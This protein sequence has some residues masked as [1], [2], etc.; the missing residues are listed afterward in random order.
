MTATYV[1]PDLTGS[2]AHCVAEFSDESQ[3]RFADWMETFFAEGVARYGSVDAF[4]DALRWHNDL[5]HF[6][7]IAP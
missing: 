1:V 4:T 3:Q 2:G 5:C 7:K 6:R